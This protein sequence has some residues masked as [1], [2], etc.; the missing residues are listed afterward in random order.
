MI[1]AMGPLVFRWLS[2]E[3]WARRGAW[4]ILTAGVIRTG[5]YPVKAMGPHLPRLSRSK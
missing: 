3:Q 2:L 1:R 5:V 4:D